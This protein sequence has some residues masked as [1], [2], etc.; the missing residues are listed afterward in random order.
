MVKL[1]NIGALNKEYSN[2]NLLQGVMQAC[3]LLPLKLL[4]HTFP[5]II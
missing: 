5:Q 3:Q 2:I 4:T 1:F